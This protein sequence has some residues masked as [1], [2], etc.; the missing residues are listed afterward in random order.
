MQNK[1][2]QVSVPF[3]ILN[4]FIKVIKLALQNLLSYVEMK[5]QLDATEV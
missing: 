4:I 2:N 1:F 3:K 5:C